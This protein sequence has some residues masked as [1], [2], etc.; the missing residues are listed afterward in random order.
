MVYVLKA[1]LAHDSAKSPSRSARTA[2]HE[3]KSKIE[4]ITG[5]LRYYILETEHLPEHM[6]VFDEAQRAWD[7]NYG[8]TKFKHTD[9]EAGIVLDI[10]QRHRDYAVINQYA[11]K[12]T[13]G[14]VLKGG[15]LEECGDL[16]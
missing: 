6:I 4:S 2:K 9:S 14:G 10:M 13:S 16:F 3:T 12:P 8:A 11:S 15:F 7:A 5:F 1:A